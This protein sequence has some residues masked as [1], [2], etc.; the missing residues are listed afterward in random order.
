MAYQDILVHLD[1]SRGCPARL[2]A[3]VS[4][5]QALGARLT[6]LYIMP[7]PDL[8]PNAR[9]YV[10]P[11]T[12]VAE[13]HAV[14]DKADQQQAAFRQAVAAVKLNSEWRCVTGEPGRQLNYHARFHD[15]L[16]IGQTDP[17][18]PNAIGGGFVSDVV[19]GAGRPVLIIPYIGAR[20]TLGRRVLV[21]WSGSREAT[22]AVHDALPLLTLA[23]QVAV[24]SIGAEGGTEAETSAKELC[25]H[26]SHYGIAATASHLPADDIEVGDLLLDRAA[27][28]DFDLIVM[29]AYGHARLR[30]IILGG[31]TR[32]LLEHMTAP[33]LLSH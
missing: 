7:P 26:L 27:D 20:P 1:E 19:L 33:V 13:R 30:E 11:E 31:A 21:A 32:H 5:A 14:R 2:T 8:P 6:G 15:L 10:T 4:L 25:G 29:G 24:L 9:A 12:I 16:I 22:R 17:E 23:Q 18:D 3:A 28:E